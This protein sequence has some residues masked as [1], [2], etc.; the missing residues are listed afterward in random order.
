MWFQAAECNAVNAGLLLNLIT[1]GL[2][3]EKKVQLHNVMLLVDDGLWGLPLN[4]NRIPSRHI[5]FSGQLLLLERHYI[6]GAVTKLLQHCCHK[7]RR[8]K[9]SR[10]T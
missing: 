8:R 3:D 2:V 4:S 1:V 6:S 10:L 9:S 7:N 5:F